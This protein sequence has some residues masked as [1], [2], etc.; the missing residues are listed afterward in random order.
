MSLES[1]LAKLS[2]SL[3]EWS[4]KG[5]NEAQTSQVIIL[6]VL[7][8]LGFNIWDPHEVAAQIHSGGGNGAYAPDFTVE[9]AGKL[10]FII[11]VKALNREFSPND[12]TQ[13]V[14]YVNAL[15]RRWAVLTN[16]KAWHFYDNQVPKPAADKLELTIELKDARAATYLA[17]LLSR[18]VW[19]ASDAE[20]HLTVEVQSISAEIRRRLK[21]SEVEEKLRNE[22]REGFALDEKGLT[23]AIQLTLEPNERELAEGSFAELTKRLLGIDRAPK[24]LPDPEPESTPEMV[25]QKD[26]LAAIIEGMRKTAP[27]QRG[28]RSSELQAWLGDTELQATSWRDINSGIVEAM[29]ALGHEDFV[30]SKGYIYQTMQSRAK[31]DGTLYPTS[32]YRQ[33]S[34]GRFLFLHDSANSHVQ[35]SRRMLEELQVPPRTVRVVYRGDTFYLP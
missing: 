17:R 26:V 25:E 9:L 24:E 5:L 13:A 32:A 18:S 30:V 21:L 33:M 12:T 29:I 7:H 28:K 19:E 15:G 6:P 4:Q 20:H 16:G 3:S 11:E 14:N 2:S 22:L 8:A 35:R 10:C 1:T 34:D 23:K 31:A 27:N